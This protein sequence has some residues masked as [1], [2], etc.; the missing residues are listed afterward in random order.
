MKFAYLTIIIG[1]AVQSAL[2]VPGS[3]IQPR[4]T[5]S[6]LI[7]PDPQPDLPRPN[8]NARISSASA[9]AA[10]A[11]NLNDI[12]GDILIGMKKNK[13]RFF[14]FG[15]N[16]AATFKS[17]LASDIKSLVTTTN[18][19]L[20]VNTQPTTAVNIAFSHTGLTTLGVT[21]SLGESLFDQGQF[22]DLSSL[23]DIESNWVP[24]FKGTG[25]HGV[26]LLASDTVANL[27]DQLASIQSILGDSITEIHR[28][29]GA[30]RPGDQEGHEHFGYMDGISQPAVQGFTQ[31]VLP[32]QALL[33]P[34]EFL[35]GTDGDSTTRPDWATGG[36]F[37]AFRQMQ[38]K[39]PE[40]SKFVSDHALSVPGLSQE[41]NAD[42]F[43][44]RLIGRWKSGAPVDLAPLHDD[45]N[46]AN[47][48]TRNNDFTFD[49]PDEAGFNLATNQTNCP[50]SAHIRKTRP[51]ADLG[52]ENTGHHIIRAGI[53]YG[54]EVTDDEASS[55]TSSTDPSLERGLAFVAYQSSIQNGFHFMQQSWV[56]NANFIFGKPTPPGVDPI[57]G[58]EA[59]S[60]MDTARPVSG[61][62]PLNPSQSV[63]LDIEFVINRGG[64]YFFS[65]PIS[66]L[67][68]KLAA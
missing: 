50:F 3:H 55:G 30:A 13:E 19:L 68:G 57:I 58:R 34:G 23:G 9:A 59:G 42:L 43:G 41:E 22:A 16:D 12:Q 67:D 47:D 29:E 40:F 20:S 45:V 11:L 46:L 32:G 26:F 17:K 52:S 28:V 27:D 24:G 66:A 38:Q 60:A 61:T 36:S 21:D 54:P 18:Q 15:I 49:H 65:P 10:S 14:F 63:S 5:K 25:V 31:S 39:V 48:N 51:R 4:R 37:L 62:D 56:N 53:P 33:N 64:E 6:L 44:A 2:A 8:N 7:S 1:L 35:L